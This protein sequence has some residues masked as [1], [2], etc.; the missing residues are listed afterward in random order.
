MKA[1][2]LKRDLVFKIVYSYSACVRGGCDT[3]RK[4]ALQ[5][6]LPSLHRS[7]DTKSEISRKNLKVF[8]NAMKA[9]IF[10]DRFG[11]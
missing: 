1:W 8:S 11:F 10:E 9:V 2:Y 5:F 4:V 7:S 6:S 3:Y